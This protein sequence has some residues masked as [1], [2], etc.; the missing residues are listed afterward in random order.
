MSVTDPLFDGDGDGTLSPTSDIVQKG[1]SDAGTENVHATH[2]KGVDVA[3][4]RV[5]TMD[6]K[7]VSDV[8]RVDVQ[9]TRRRRSIVAVDQPIDVNS[10]DM[11]GG[12]RA[13]SETRVEEDVRECGDDQRSKGRWEASQLS[14]ESHLSIPR[15]AEFSHAQW[16]TKHVILYGK[17]RR[18]EG[19]NLHFTSRPNRFETRTLCEERDRLPACTD[20]LGCPV[21]PHIYE[22]TWRFAFLFATPCVMYRVKLGKFFRP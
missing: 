13:R 15:N 3:K 7:V 10:R 18:Y 8:L 5:L 21:K 17:I 1:P 6:G 20:L 12:V 14:I 2:S 4:A 22:I 11:N 9:G 19:C 16:R